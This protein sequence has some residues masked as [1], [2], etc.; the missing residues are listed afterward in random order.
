MYLRENH[1]NSSCENLAFWQNVTLALETSV[2]PVL[3]QQLF[4]QT[5]I[6]A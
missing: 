1:V 3:I 2:T 6:L 4:K 5:T